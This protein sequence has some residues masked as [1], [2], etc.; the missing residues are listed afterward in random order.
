MEGLTGRY[1]EKER[2]ARYNRVAA[3]EADQDRLLRLLEE[4]TGLKAEA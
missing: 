1:F 2:V 4:Q 3:I